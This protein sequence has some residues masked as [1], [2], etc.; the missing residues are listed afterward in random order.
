M[1]MAIAIYHDANSLD[2]DD[3]GDPTP[4][5]AYYRTQHLDHDWYNSP[6]VTTIVHSRSTAVGDI[7]ALPDGTLLVVASCG[8]TPIANASLPAEQSLL[9]RE[10]RAVSAT[11]LSAVTRRADLT[12]LAAGL[13]H[14]TSQV[15]L[16][17]T[18][19][20]FALPVWLM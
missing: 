10:L 14:L 1:R 20:N 13:Q 2:Y 16:L 18:A 11:L 15:A 7:L 4:Q 6:G 12:S 19:L 3:R 8:F 9:V 5:A 17:Y